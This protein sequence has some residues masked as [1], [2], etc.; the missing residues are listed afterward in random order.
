MKASLTEVLAGLLGGGTLT[1]GDAMQVMKSLGGGDTAPA[2]AG[3]LLAA[4]R[5]RG[6]S[7]EEIRGFALAMRELAIRPELPPG[8]R[9]VD[10]SGTGGDGAGSLNLST[11]AGLLA[12]AAGMSVFKHG[13]R[14]VSSKSGSSDV[15]AALNIPLPQ[16][17]E[18]ATQCLIDCGFAFLFAPYF[19]PAMK[20]IAPVRQAMG[21]RTVFNV[22]GPLTNPA[23]PEYQIIGAFSE[24]VAQLMAETMSGMPVERAFVVHGAPG[25][26]EVTPVGPF[27]LL[28]VR[29]GQV[30]REVRDP[31]D[32]GLPRCTPDD[33]AGGDAQFNARALESALRGEDRGPH[34]DAL[35]LATGL[36]LELTG[37]ADGLAQ[38]IEQARAA[39][40]DGAGQQL[41]DKLRAWNPES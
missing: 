29:P 14:A 34:L 35:A 21:V 17:A 3:A 20:A 22:L 12:A 16:T 36:A 30:T 33:L 41:L 25:W 4:L 27:L 6:E 28:D 7:A 40:T 13:N 8:S 37:E 10:I 38:G 11:G 9:P 18:A 31:A 23:Q 2:M 15:L 32:Y 24:E 1:E 26:D 5:M 39:A 19:H